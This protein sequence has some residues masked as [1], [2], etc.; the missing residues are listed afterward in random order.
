MNWLDLG[1]ILFITI[2]LIIGIKKGFMTSVLSNFSFGMNALLSFFL[3]KPISHIYNWMGVGGAI[4]KSYAERA[5]A[6]SA[7]FGTN[8]I[9]MSQETLSE[10]VSSTI[11]KGGF[12]GISKSMFKLF[13]NKPTLYEE[14][15]ASGHTTRSLADIISSSYSSFFV[16]IISFVTSVALLYLTVFLISLLV[17]KLREIGFVKVVDTTLGALYGLFKCFIVLVGICIVIKLLSPISF[18]SSVTN[19]ISES[20]FGKLIYNQVN[21]FIDNY[22]SFSDIIKVIFKK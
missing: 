12:G 8:L 3:C 11:D 10:F 17:K 2:L 16:T 21:A 14:L 22:L 1:L 18:M 20:F 13:I 9:G 15:N 6:A 4:S 7:D 19:Y 5:L